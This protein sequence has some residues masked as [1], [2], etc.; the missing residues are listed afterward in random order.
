M[1]GGSYRAPG[2]FWPIISYRVH[3]MKWS[4][5]DTH[6]A[7]I[8][9]ESGDFTCFCSKFHLLLIT[10]SRI[11]AKK[12]RKFHSNHSVFMYVCVYMCVCVCLH[13]K[14]FQW[15]MSQ[16][17]VPLLEYVHD[18]NLKLAGIIGSSTP[19]FHEQLRNTTWY[20]SKYALFN[21][22]HIISYT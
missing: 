9:G 20:L 16:M 1:M 14:S 3:G 17:Y 8:H 6:C 7:W 10:H 19:W 22:C 2:S 18:S 13:T 11:T 21:T 15:S 12:I 4:Y 5:A